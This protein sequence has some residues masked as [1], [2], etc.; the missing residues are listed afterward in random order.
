MRIGSGFDIHKLVP[1]RP[2]MLG[3][4]EIPYHLGLLGHSDADVL[5]H[6]FCDALLGAA[7]L[8]D[9]GVHFPDTD[10]TYKDIYSI[11]LLA[12]SYKMVREEGYSLVNMDA[13]IM[14]QAPKL[15]P[16]IEKMKHKIAGALKVKT[17][18]INIKATTYEGLGEIGKEEAISAQCV[19][20]L[21]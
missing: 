7:G 8:G 4:V 6:A 3:G 13:T 1:G 11:E 20:L 17:G 5:V 21:D 10:N 2:L 19:V 18:R 16:H 14:A 15:I 9:I 12:D